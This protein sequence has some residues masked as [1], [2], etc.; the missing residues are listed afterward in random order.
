M[1]VLFVSSWAPVPGT[2]FGGAKRLYYLARELGRHCELSVLALDGCREL[3]PGDPPPRDFARYLQLP[4]VTLPGALGRWELLPGVRAL[5]A[6]HRE[7]IRAF[8]GDRP[9][10]ATLFAFPLALRFLESDW[11]ISLGRKLYLEDDLMEERYREAA[12]QGPWP[13]RCAARLRAAQA[14]RFFRRRLE[15]MA[16][17]VGISREETEVMRARHPRLPVHV[18]GYGVPM[19]DFPLL[20]EPAGRATLGFIGNYRHP[21]NADAAAWLIGEVFPKVAARTPGARLVLAGPHLPSSLSERCSQEGPVRYLGEVGAVA[22]F[23]RE[24]GIFVNAVREG[25]G[26]R[27]KAIEAAAFGR[28]IVSTRLGA[29]GLEGLALGLGD[30][31]ESLARAVRQRLDQ[32]LWRSEAAANRAAVE[33]LFSVEALG[34]ELAGWLAGREKGEAGPQGPGTPA[35]RGR[36]TRM[37]ARDAGPAPAA[38]A[39]GTEAGGR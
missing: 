34:A 12:R 21:P 18:L 36:G 16:G 28:P 25:R 6:R 24:I 22:D 10:D 33:R 38:G 13:R 31:P 11:G 19:A 15:G 32:D 37:D 4:Q 5:F 1:R 27:T 8:L 39:P 2:R 26:L 9:F 30:D 3:G 29:E 14:G 20:P 35:A 7:A 17:F 23:F